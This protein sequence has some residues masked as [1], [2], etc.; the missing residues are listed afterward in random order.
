MIEITT[1]YINGNFLFSKHTHDYSGDLEKNKTTLAEAGVVIILLMSI[2]PMVS[3]S[4]GRIKSHK[5]TP[6]G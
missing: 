4:I 2:L 5:M 1:V 3:L 6:K